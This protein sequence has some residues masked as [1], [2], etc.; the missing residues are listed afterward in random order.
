MATNLFSSY[1]QGENRVTS[2]LMAVHTA[3][4]STQHAGRVLQALLD[5]DDFN[6]ATFENLPYLR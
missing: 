6:L 2:T 3:S 5:R 1:R 4:E